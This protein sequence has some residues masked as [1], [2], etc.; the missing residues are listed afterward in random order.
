MSRVSGFEGV[1]CAADVD[2]GLIAAVYCGFVDNVVGLTVA[3]QRTFGFIGFV[4]VAGCFFVFLCSCHQYC[5]V[6]AL[7]NVAHVAG[8]AVA[9]LYGVSV[10][11]F[12][13]FAGL[14]EV[15]AD[16]A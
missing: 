9:E 6:V 5:V 13:E 10:D 12:V 4:T 1:G 14:G 8:A 11:Y 7:D 2:C 15:L 16:Q 3:F